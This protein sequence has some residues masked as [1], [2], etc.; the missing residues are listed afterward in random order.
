MV[1][2]KD[3]GESVKSIDVHST[4]LSSDLGEPF[5]V[6]EKAQIHSVLAESSNGL[7]KARPLFELYQGETYWSSPFIWPSKSK[8]VRGNQDD[9]VIVKMAA[10][11]EHSFQEINIDSNLSR[12]EHCI[13]RLLENISILCKFA[14]AFIHCAFN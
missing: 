3:S 1:N 10:S 12:D 9:A 5:T 6:L 14:L 7:Q 11:D 13:P 2:R 8:A 4:C